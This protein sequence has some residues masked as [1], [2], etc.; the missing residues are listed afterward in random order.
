MQTAAMF[1][2]LLV[3][4][5]CFGK[6]PLKHLIYMAKVLRWE[7]PHFHNGKCYIN[8]FFPP[9]P[10]KAFDRFLAAVIA[11]KRIPYST[12][13]AVTDKCPFKC[14]HCS[15]GFHQKG[16]MDTKH[17][18]E[19]IKQI[20]SLG[21]ITI[22]FTGGEPLLRDD[23]V[24]LV[25]T[26]GD[27][28]ASIIFSTGHRLTKERAFNLADAGLNCLMIG[29]ENGNASEH[30]N[31]RGV[32]GSF[33]EAL[34]AIEISLQAGLYTAISTAATKDKIKKGVIHRLAE[35]GVKLGVHE[36]RILEPI[37]T[38][39]MSGRTDEI[40]TAD[41]T[42]GLSDFHK[43]WNIRKKGLAVAAFSHLESAE[44][45]GCGAG[46]HHL[47]IDAVGNV[48]PCDLTPLSF[49]N[50]LD[51]PLGN[52]WQKMGQYFCLPRSV[53]F[54]KGICRNSVLSDEL[55]MSAPKTIELCA[56]NLHDGR[57]PKIYENLFNGQIPVNQPM[58]QSQSH[59]LQ[60]KQS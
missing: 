57:L 46:Y 7:N 17:A 11:H 56:N 42:K 4:L 19:T 25:R 44:M 1:K 13:F 39:N 28:T 36:F 24:E 35:L 52:I 5:R 16:S 2:F 23:I 50:L 45:F 59:R 54:M 47:F 12:Y 22:G 29:I 55:P 8:T 48:C 21:T 15:Y 37:P 18:I 14:P 10:S 6:L 26:V 51:E 9:Y 27:D 60:D 43:Q 53:C 58:L 33:D 34:R 3:F 40:L 49:G 20:K 32:T 30:D 41:E 38:G 31:T